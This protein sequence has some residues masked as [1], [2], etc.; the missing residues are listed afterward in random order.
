MY[1]QDDD[2]FKIR[3]PEASITYLGL[4]TAALGTVT[5]KFVISVWLLS[6]DS[7]H[8]TDCPQVVIYCK[9]L[10]KFFLIGLSNY[11]W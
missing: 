1:K 5:L 4:V 9:L 8:N 7:A 6:H 3:G 2:L 10:W 11:G